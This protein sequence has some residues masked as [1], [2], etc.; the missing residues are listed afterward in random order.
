MWGQMVEGSRL[1]STER[2]EGRRAQM[3]A[4]SGRRRVG[5]AGPQPGAQKT[6][7]LSVLRLE[8]QSQGS[9][10]LVPPRGSEG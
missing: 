7:T 8:V 1:P 9:A 5:T 3:A 6:P 4:A 10:T 2:G